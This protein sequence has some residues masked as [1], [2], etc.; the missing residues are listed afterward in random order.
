MESD[1]GQKTIC[2]YWDNF[3]A[4]R[5]VVY[6]YYLLAPSRSCRH[7]VVNFTISSCW[8]VSHLTPPPSTPRFNPLTKCSIT[9]TTPQCIWAQLKLAVLQLFAYRWHL[10][11]D[12]LDPRDANY[13]NL[14]FSLYMFVQSLMFS[15]QDSLKLYESN[16][17]DKLNNDYL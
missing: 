14:R 17:L 9:H 10:E 3:S 6:E 16:K 2:L 12:L 15:L 11:T 1:G 5:K 4:L 13:Y 8:G 7:S